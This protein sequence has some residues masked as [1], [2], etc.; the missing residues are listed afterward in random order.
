MYSFGVVL[1][2]LLTR[3]KAINQDGTIS[4]ELEEMLRQLDIH[5]WTPTNPEETERLLSEHTS[6]SETVAFSYKKIHAM[7]VEARH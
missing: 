4:R 3:Q 7:D 1:A 2:E 6:I 5:P